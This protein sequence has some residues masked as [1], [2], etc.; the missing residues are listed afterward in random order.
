MISFDPVEYVHMRA[1]LLA[2]PKQEA[3]AVKIDIQA[4]R[5]T[6]TLDNRNHT[7]A[8]P[9]P[10]DVNSPQNTATF[11]QQSNHLVLRLQVKL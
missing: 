11:H 5:V 6:F 9:K 4:K 7:T 2:E 8:F 3:K 10:V 1:K